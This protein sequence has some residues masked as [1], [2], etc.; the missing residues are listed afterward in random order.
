M[1]HR[2]ESRRLSDHINAWS[3]GGTLVQKKEA[4]KQL[5]TPR[6]RIDIE[7]LQEAEMNFQKKL[8]LQ[9]NDSVFS[10]TNFG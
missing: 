7:L 4:L 10:L 9:E 6:L 8:I 2:W 5:S 1:G 3:S